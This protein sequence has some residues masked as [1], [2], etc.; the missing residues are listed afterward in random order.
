MY[1]T[2]QKNAQTRKDSFEIFLISSKRKPNLIETDRSKDFYNSI[3]WKF[4][5][6]NKTIGIFLEIH[7]LKRFNRTVRDLLKRPFLERGDANWIN[8]LLT[9]TK[10]YNKR[11]HT[12]TRL[13]PN[14]A[15]SNKNEGYVYN[16]LLDKQNKVKT[17]SFKQK[18]L[19]RTADLKKTFSK[20]DPTNWSYKLYKVTGIINDTISNYRLDNSPE[21]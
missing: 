5:T 2:S 6:N 3:F 8:V 17:Q 4:I 11:V 14:Q 7:P 15:S 21:R 10:Q 16:S 9:I 20:G 19:V 1:S 13:T 18:N 12:S